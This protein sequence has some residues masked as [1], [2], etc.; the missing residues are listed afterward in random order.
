VVFRTV[1]VKAS[2]TLHHQLREVL[3]RPCRKAVTRRSRN[4]RGKLSAGLALASRKPNI[5]SPA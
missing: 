3:A 1:S 4:L 5:I 2:L